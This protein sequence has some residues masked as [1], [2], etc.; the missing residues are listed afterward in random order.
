MTKLESLQLSEQEEF[1]LEKNGSVGIEKR[2]LGAVLASC[3]RSKGKRLELL[4]CR[5]SREAAG[6]WEPVLW[7]RVLC[8]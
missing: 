6:S 2:S 3:D 5:S 4:K 7:G 1:I 8:C